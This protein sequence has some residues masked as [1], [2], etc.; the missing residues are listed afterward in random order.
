MSRARLIVVLS[1][2]VAL[3]SV[4]VVLISIGNR[5]SPTDCEM[6]QIF[7][8]PKEEE[9]FE[10]FLKKQF[11]VYGGIEPGGFFSD[12]RYSFAIYR[13]NTEHNKYKYYEYLISRAGVPH[14]R[15]AMSISKE[16]WESGN[17]VECK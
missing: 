6:A 11:R 13:P 16:E 7:Y 10:T 8:N 5:V 9:M 15:L 3:V 17:K 14:S 1:L 4:A 12:P 2:A